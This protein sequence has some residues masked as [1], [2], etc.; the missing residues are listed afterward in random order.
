[1][2]VSE[3][4]EYAAE[5]QKSRLK[6]PDNPKRSPSPTV[7]HEV[8]EPA[9]PT[10]SVSN[11]ASSAR[12]TPS[13][14]RKTVGKNAAPSTESAQNA[15][16]SLRLKHG[17]RRSSLSAV[18]KSMQSGGPSATPV[19]KRDSSNFLPEL[20]SLT[21]SSALMKYP[22]MCDTTKISIV[23]KYVNVLDVLPKRYQSIET[24]FLSHNSIAKLENI[25]QFK[26]L[27]VLS[28]ADN[29]VQDISELAYLSECPHLTI[30]NL[31]GNPLCDS[32]NYR[33]HAV[34]SMPTIRLL[35]NI[36]VNEVERKKASVVVA[37]EASLWQMLI[38]NDQLVDLLGNALLRVRVHAE[39]KASFFGRMSVVNRAELPPM[40]M[41][42]VGKLISGSLGVG[43]SD[44]VRSQ[45]QVM[46][47]RRL[48]LGVSHHFKAPI[49]KSA[50]GE[51][52]AWDKA[53]SALLL[54]QQNKIASL[55][56]RMEE[57][58]QKME[59]LR[60]RY[61]AYDPLNVVNALR[62]EER[63][64]SA[65]AQGE[66]EGLIREFVQTIGELLEDFKGDY[67]SQAEGYEGRIREMQRMLSGM[68][69]GG[70]SN[71][72]LS[73]A[74]PLH[75]PLH[76]QQHPTAM[77]G[78][79][80]GGPSGAQSG[81]SLKK[82]MGS[83]R[84]PGQVHAA[85]SSAGTTPQAKAGMTSAH[86]GGG[87]GGGNHNHNHNHTMHPA[88]R[89]MQASPSAST[90]GP[91]LRADDLLQSRLSPPRRAPAPI[92]RSQSSPAVHLPPATPT[93]ASAVTAFPLHKQSAAER[94]RSL[95][96]AA[97]AGGVSKQTSLLPKSGSTSQLETNAL[98]EQVEI[99]SADLE[100]RAMSEKRLQTVN[101]ML[102]ERLEAVTQAGTVAIPEEQLTVLQE[103]LNQAQREKVHLERVLQAL[104]YEEEQAAGDS[105]GSPGRM[106]HAKGEDRIA[107]SSALV[108]ATEDNEELVAEVEHWHEKAQ[109]AQSLYEQLHY[110]Q[111][112]EARIQRL[113]NRALMNRAFFKWEFFVRCQQA[114]VALDS[115]EDEDEDAAGEEEVGGS[116]Q[117]RSALPSPRILLVNRLFRQ[118]RQRR[119]EELK[120]RVFQR[121]I[122]Q[123]A[124]S[125]TALQG[126]QT[127]QVE[128]MWRIWQAWRQWSALQVRI[129]RQAGLQ[130]VRN[131][132]TLLRTAFEEWRTYAVT[133]SSSL[134]LSRTDILESTLFSSQNASMLAPMEG[135]ALLAR[136]FYQRRY[137]EAW[138]YFVHHIR[139]PYILGTQKAASHYRLK[140]LMVG[141]DAFVNYVPIAR[142][143]EKFNKRAMAHCRQQRLNV[144]YDHWVA[145]VILRRKF[146]LQKNE[147][148]LFRLQT[149]WMRWHTA[150]LNQRR[151]LQQSKVAEKHRRHRLQQMA[152]TVWSSSLASLY[153]CRR[154]EVVVHEKRSQHLAA[155][156]WKQWRAAYA[157]L[158]RSRQQGVVRQLD[159][160]R[161]IL[162]AWRAWTEYSL[163]KRFQLVRADRHRGH[164]ER[165]FLV[166]VFQSWSAHVHAR[167]EQRK[168][169]Y[170]LQLS[171]SSRTMRSALVQWSL[172]VAM[173]RKSRIEQMKGEV[174]ASVTESSSA[175]EAFASMQVENL[176]LLDRIQGLSEE[177]AK[178]SMENNKMSSRLGVLEGLKEEADIL[179]SGQ[180]ATIAKLNAAN[181]DALE[182]VRRLHAALS[183]QQLDRNSMTLHSTVELR[184]KQ[185][186]IDRLQEEVRMLQNRLQEKEEE[187][188]AAKQTASLA[189]V[190]YSDKVMSAFEIATQL[191]NL[192][193][194]RE[195]EITGL[196]HKL[197]TAE[198]AAS[199]AQNMLQD[200]RG[201]HQS[202][203]VDADRRQM[204]LEN[205]LRLTT[206]ALDE[207][208]SSRRQ[209]DVWLESSASEIKKL[210][211]EVAL[212]SERESRHTDD[213]IKEVTRVYS[214]ESSPIFNKV[215]SS[216]IATD[217]TTQPVPVFGSG[218]A[219]T[220]TSVQK[221]LLQVKEMQQ[222]TSLEEP[223]S[224]LIQDSSETRAE[225]M[226]SPT[227]RSNV[228]QEIAVLQERLMSHLQNTSMRSL[229][230]STNST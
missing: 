83:P 62:E 178:L 103:E 104:R 137:L 37:K 188:M 51:V 77:T 131:E 192:V 25:G 201:Q 141:M 216:R 135:M 209:L 2:T 221:S 53:F 157:G 128:G 203:K 140:L 211:F 174:R 160:L 50:T 126:R 58:K 63:Q 119:W 190:D 139:R 167:V 179:A 159:N 121:W 127:R 199:S 116:E 124:L 181:A 68:G 207:E 187:M 123:V 112:R 212:L 89:G 143:E 55:L 86:K 40:T 108:Q 125:K 215:P 34:L 106:L 130:R 97:A 184:S 48:Q 200:Y 57:E 129:R 29:C 133:I 21:L 20:P 60:Q 162:A 225:S 120:I 3:N 164:Q 114:Q 210:Q 26:E 80:S 16:T 92:P 36:D 15:T 84:L 70:V 177:N 42:D 43:P 213:F 115:S 32:P 148:E 193:E 217:S 72:S 155:A 96:G 47:R 65:I 5:A 122:W 198:V 30:C 165:R 136:R 158:Q 222:R 28:M 76:P 151:L 110:S 105:S 113:G 202:T 46:R 59:A 175:E 132:R 117:T 227:R 186:S 197:R 218:A 85:T 229:D 183:E 27:R 24:L 195:T 173:G 156:A 208:R 71:P 61:Q 69:M 204:E 176:M 75:Q 10:E 49:P 7:E 226:D 73:S 149:L 214:R 224:A 185:Q 189:D 223:P 101:K 22:A 219:Q 4:S 147:G 17:A 33:S 64:R 138:R 118:Q 14:N 18:K 196:Q 78:M 1:M 93:S 39:L 8:A 9:P 87:K 100:K 44:G 152:F 109:E 81:S 102:Y 88:S 169:L 66:R 31:E 170:R 82:S 90:V 171:N 67:H 79:M 35:D 161:D 166:A 23:E 134:S 168:K 54:S 11:A 12:S 144:A 205:E 111:S 191:R 98:L 220:A 107:L 206:A 74:A 94:E 99:L 228:H 230:Q 180:E 95:Q 52:H 19:V 172:H 6:N 150:Q 45:W 154:V 153:T 13:N 182:E 38:S 41:L 91:P 194:E 163:R 142:E 145:F 56:S 146:K